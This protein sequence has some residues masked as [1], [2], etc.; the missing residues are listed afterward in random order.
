MDEKELELYQERLRSKDTWGT[1]DLADFFGVSSETIRRRIKDGTIT[2]SESETNLG[3]R[4]TVSSEEIV[5]N[6]SQSDTL[7]KYLEDQD[8]PSGRTSPDQSENMMDFVRSLR[9]EIERKDERIEELHDK[10]D[11]LQ[12]TVGNLREKAG[13]LETEN[14]HLRAELDRLTEDEETKAL[15]EGGAVDLAFNTARGALDVVE[16]FARKILPG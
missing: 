1:Q 6:V 15:P 5:R 12:E 7:Q 8:E 9:T 2:A 4:W 3:T 10:I 14:Q 11:S 13:K 16:G